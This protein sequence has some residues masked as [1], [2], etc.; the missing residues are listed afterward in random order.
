MHGY[1]L[2]DRLGAL[3]SEDV[4]DLGNLYRL[5]RAL[6]ADAVV[7]S[8]W[9]GDRPGPARRVYALSSEGHVLLDRWAEALERSQGLVARFLD[10]YHSQEVRR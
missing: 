2:A 3:V 9:R 10:R 5:L 4:V 7:A 8:E 6:E 1:E